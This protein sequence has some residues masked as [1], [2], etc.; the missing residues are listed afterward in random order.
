MVLVVVPQS[1]K[2]VPTFFHPFFFYSKL[3]SIFCLWFIESVRWIC[4][5]V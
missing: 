2:Q 1:E 4:I 5:Y 3:K